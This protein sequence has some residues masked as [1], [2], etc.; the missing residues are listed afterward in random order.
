VCRSW[1]HEPRCNVPAAFLYNLFSSDDKGKQKE[2]PGHKGAAE[3]RK[4]R[5]QKF[6]P[7]AEHH[8][9][10]AGIIRIDLPEQAYQKCSIAADW[11]AQTNVAQLATSTWKTSHTEG[12]LLKS[13]LLLVLLPTNLFILLLTLS[14][15]ITHQKLVRVE[16]R[17]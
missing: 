1:W 12:A 14:G 3:E 16:H 15:C 6:M 2:E 17:E 9:K 5:S 4:A 7:R 11:L 8:K 10:A 13:S